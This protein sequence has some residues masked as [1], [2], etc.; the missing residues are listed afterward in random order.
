MGDSLLQSKLMKF[1]EKDV[2]LEFGGK[3][4]QSA[5]TEGFTEKSIVFIL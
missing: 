3:V 5:E 4:A 1:V 2:H